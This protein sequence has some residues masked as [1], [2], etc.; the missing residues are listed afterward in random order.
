MRGCRAKSQVSNHCS[1]NRTAN[2]ADAGRRHKTSPTD[3]SWASGPCE[4]AA[5]SP[6]AAGL[7]AAST[8]RCSGRMPA[9][10]RCR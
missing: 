10:W 3:R 2:G 7:A 9:P 4:D 8:R 6:G 1:G 5:A